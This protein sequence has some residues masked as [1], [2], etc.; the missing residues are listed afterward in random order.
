MSSKKTLLFTRPS[1]LLLCAF[2]LGIPGLTGIS[3]SGQS[4][5]TTPAPAKTPD[6]TIQSNVDEV[7][8]DVVVRSKKNKVVSDLKPEDLVITDN[9]T[10]VKISDLHMMTGGA[11]ENRLVTM[12]FD[13]LD[14]AAANNARSIAGKILKEFP[15]QGFS[16]SVLGITGRL[17]LY[18]NFTEDRKLLA[19]K[20]RA[21]TEAS[22]EEASTASATAEKNLLMVARTG[23]DDSGTHVNAEQRATA[24][25]V[26]Y[27]LQDSQKIM[28]EQRTR[29]ALAGL[30]ALAR[31]QGKVPGRK[32]LI[33]FSQQTREDGTEEDTVNTI[34]GA[35]NRSGVSIC[36]VDA[37]IYFD[38][39][40]QALVAAMALGNAVSMT[41]SRV[42]AP[43]PLAGPPPAPQGDASAAGMH[44]VINSQNDRFEIRGAEGKGP[45]AI[46]GYATGGAFIAAGQNPRN[47]AQELMRDLST[48][49]QL[50]YVP[51]FKEYD[52]TFRAVSI[53]PTRKDLRVRTRA[54]YFALAPQN[55]ASFKLFETPLLKIFSD[56]QLPTDVK[57]YARVLHLG[58]V[59]TADSTALAV[60]VPISE[61]D[62][63]DDPNT[64]LYSLHASII[65]QIKNSK[66]EVIEHFSEDMPRHGALDAK[67]A[68]KNSSVVM[69]RHLVAEP[70]DYVLEVV[71]VDR[72]T[73]KIGAIRTPFTIASTPS[74]AFLSDLTLVGRMDPLPDDMDANDPMKYGDRRIVPNLVGHMQRGVK[75]ID[76]FS[77]VHASPHSG[78]QPRLELTVLRNKE[79]LAQVPLQLRP[80]TTSAA[81]PYI[82]SIQSGSLPPGDYQLIETL[83]E[84]EKTFEKSVSF[85]IE[86]PEFASA[87]APTPGL[88]SS[89]PTA[90]E[91]SMMAGAKMPSGAHQLVIT[92]LPEGSVPPPSSEELNN[93]VEAARKHALGY[94]KTLPNFVCVETTNRSVDAANSGDWKRRDNIAEL[95]RYVEGVET[96]TMVERNGE[97][98]NLQ[99]TD[100]D[101]SW[102]LSV[103]EF[104]GLLNLVFKAESKTDFQ[105]KE[106]A[107]LGSGTVQVL[108]YRVDPKNATMALSDSNRKVSVGFHGLV[109]VDTATAGIRRITLEADDI[110][111]DFSIHAASMNVDY[112][113][114]TIGSHEYLMPM[115]AVMMLRRGKKQIDLNEMAFRG[116][117]R[118]AS[119]TKIVTSP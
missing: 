55:S 100:L 106:A 36:A 74:D 79:P 103:G 96:R 107:S 77:V 63:H 43:Q 54:G 118:Y 67:D 6:H 23:A 56:P 53:T 18:Q 8:L 31:A 24:Q 12:V 102:P 115:R 37:N 116:Y 84:G 40:G 59:G 113:F 4:L 61:L 41:Q 45:L 66:G 73:G 76:L 11:G 99:R 98:T 109:Y 10:R 87:T 101:S 90:D 44:S 105:W 25:S 46:L 35:A 72:N 13:R 52:G 50:S 92:T 83:T 27:A 3:V 9:G 48:Y 91:L 65:A 34:L 51:P 58:D 60:E 104:G 30:L 114:V 110:P 78:Q 5:P 88:V 22:R 70:G 14:S 39:T 2:L 117:R 97:R 108:K 16:F 89:A 85:R 82:A 49:Y 21:A 112:D 28:Q 38:P 62:T 57:F 75:Q 80:I 7:S 20:I 15:A 42:G 19:E 111:R 69:Q 119:Q 17:R 81:V 86:G 68:A 1:L 93:I 95:L 47:T 29:A 26:L 94:S 71:V 64:N 33:Y 32:A